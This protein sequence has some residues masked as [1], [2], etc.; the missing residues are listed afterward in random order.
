V[1]K[2]GRNTFVIG[3]LA[4]LSY[5]TSVS[6]AI[7]N[8]RRLIKETGVDAVEREGSQKVAA[9]IKGIADAGMIVQAHIGFTTE[10]GGNGRIC[11]PG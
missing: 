4:F 6:D 2:G 11:C 9:Q 5:E 1:P 3:D 7:R 10:A 8:A